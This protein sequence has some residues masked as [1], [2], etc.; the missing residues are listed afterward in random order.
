[1]VFKFV[2]DDL[3]GVVMGLNLDDMENLGIFGVV[4]LIV[5]IIIDE[6]CVFNCDDVCV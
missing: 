5:W 1:M 2:M 3:V 4:F 6:S